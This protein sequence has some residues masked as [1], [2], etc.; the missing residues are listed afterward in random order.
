MRP[1]SK[2]LSNFVAI[3]IPS[4]SLSN[5][6]NDFLLTLKSELDSDFVYSFSSDETQVAT[7]CLWYFKSRDYCLVRRRFSRRLRSVWAR[8]MLRISSFASCVALTFFWSLLRIFW[9]ED[10]LK[11]QNCLQNVCFSF[12]TYTKC[13]TRPKISVYSSTRLSRVLSLSMRR[14]VCY[15][16][17]EMCLR[18]FYFLPAGSLAFDSRTGAPLLI[19]MANHFA[20]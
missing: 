6:R 15:S 5:M 1:R 3:L 19:D 16:P 18:C 11:V 4:I 14:E 9:L 13:E 2:F 17:C 8:M 20:L 12:L 7:L 10:V